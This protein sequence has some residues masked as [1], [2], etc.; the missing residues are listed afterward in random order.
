M[1]LNLDYGR[2]KGAAL[3]EPICALYQEAGGLLMNFFL[4]GLKLQSKGREK[5]AWK[6]RYE[7]A[8]T[9]YQRLMDPG[10]LGRRG[11]RELRGRYESLDPFVLKAEVERRLQPILAGAAE[12]AP[13]VE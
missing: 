5:S 2:L 12:V 9:A 8:R 1:S 13:R 7:P 3:V 6:K 4:P 11:R 10:V